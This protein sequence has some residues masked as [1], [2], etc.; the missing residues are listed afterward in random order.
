[1]MP[2]KIG[3]ADNKEI[4][5]WIGPCH[6]AEMKKKK[7]KRK[8]PPIEANLNQYGN[9]RWS[10]TFERPFPSTCSSLLAITKRSNRKF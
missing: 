1:M 9:I 8:T 10:I 2:I 7:K 6:R 4:T 3:M 5:S